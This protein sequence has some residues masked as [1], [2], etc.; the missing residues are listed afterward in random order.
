MTSRVGR[1]A[2]A[3]LLLALVSSPAAAQAD[4]RSALLERAGWDAIA[5][6]QPH[7]AAEAFRQALASDPGNPQLYL[8]AGTAAYLERRND[9]AKEA[10]ERA[11]QLNPRLTRA[12][13]V[14]G[15]VL[16]RL[17]DLNGAIRTYESVVSD[18]PD[19]KQ[20]I[21]LLEKWRREAALADRMQQTVGS[22]FTVSFE[23]PAVEE[24]AARTVESLDRAYWR[25]GDLLGIH[26][27]EAIAV[28]LYSAEQFEDITRSPSWAAGA[29]DGTIRVPV[30]GALD[31]PDELDRVLAHELTHALVH[32]LARRG[33]P[34]W[35]NE[36]LAGALEGRDLAW[37][38]DIVRSVQ[39]PPLSALQGSFG[40]L[41]KT[42]AQ[43]AY[44]VSALAVRRLLDEAGGFAVAN[45]LRDLGDG[46]D[47]EAA[48]A[49]RMQ[50][51]FA[52]FQASLI[53]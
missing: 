5:A 52:D 33:V 32:T 45:L 49:H 18:T 50:R 46:A 21:S 39:P 1:P 19:D 35:L 23:G 53:Y 14:L 12:R 10:L 26:P 51:T 3:A 40:R 48:F 42:Q 2:A 30:R 8:G 34:T 29:Y 16:Y 11:L 20:A 28:V 4:P 24:L 31:R 36:G 17:G 13:V 9:A 47:F 6:G 25:V 37:A 38:D 7:A 44:A 27:H 41:D 22:H 15:P 43:A